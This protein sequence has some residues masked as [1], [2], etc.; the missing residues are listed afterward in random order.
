MYVCLGSVGEKW[1][2]PP[3]SIARNQEIIPKMKNRQAEI[4]AGHLEM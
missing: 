1:D 3:I 4:L 2:K